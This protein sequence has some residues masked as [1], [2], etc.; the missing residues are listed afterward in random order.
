MNAYIVLHK[1][2]FNQ[3]FYQ[4]DRGIEPLTS[5]L[6]GRRSPTELTWRTLLTFG[7]EPKT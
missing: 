4:P 6:Q 2:P 7:L 3:L 1:T 5:E